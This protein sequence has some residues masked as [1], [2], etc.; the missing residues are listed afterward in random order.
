MGWLDALPQELRRSRPWLC[1]SQ[2]WARAYTGQID[3]V[4]TLL[5]DAERA[6][7][8]VDE[9]AEEQRIIGHIV[10]LRAYAVGIR[11]DLPQAAKLAR[12]A[13]QR[14]SEEDPMVRGFAGTLLGAALRH[15]GDFAAAA[16]VWTEVVAI[17][18]KADD[19]H[20]VVIALSALSALQIELGQLHQA[21]AT[22][23]EALRVADE[24][25]KRGGRRLPVTG[26]VYARMSALWREWN[27]LE[28]AIRYARESL[29]ISKRWGQA[30][31]LTTSHLVL[32]QALQAI[33]DADAALDAVREARQVAGNL[34]PWYKD[35]MAAYEARLWL[36]Q[37]N[38]SAASHWAQESGL[39]V[40]DQVT[41]DRMPQYLVLARSL[42]AQ[43]QGQGRGSL[44]E[45]LKLLVRLLEM[46]ETA[47]ATG[48][49]I[50]TLA[51]QAV[52][53]WAENKADQALSALERA[54]S[55]AEPEGYVRTFVDEDVL[56]AK[57]LRRAAA[58]G[59]ALDY[60]NR[61][62][63][64]YGEPEYMSTGVKIP[65]PHAQP[66]IEP[67]SERELE[68]LRLLTTSLS[69]TDIAAELVISVS[70]VRSH[71]KSIYG[72]LNVHRRADAV[73]RAKELGF[74]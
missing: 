47:G 40:D 10:A 21:A 15:S 55:L 53:L 1:V 66:L 13:L 62:L 50:E 19:R 72:K 52:A 29:A 70:T 60:V 22:C 46:A 69:S 44:H 39:A 67:L 45:G 71:I 3:A 28:V 18:Q 14:L 36:A 34:S 26:P 42:V 35:R 8:S 27:D 48:Y 30:E 24:Y 61:L 51:L 17:S 11:G 65:H 56:M 4:E 9:H 33:G 20:G 31:G 12:E 59:I 41:F 38:L 57:L 2:A 43:G 37:G 23:Q 25:M 5:Q 58:Q 54:L 49:V 16:K 68:V 73:H 63:A 32:A 7:A 74:L 64:A 6:L